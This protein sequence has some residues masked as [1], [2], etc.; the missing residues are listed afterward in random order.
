MKPKP[1]AEPVK[2]Y[3]SEFGKRFAI[4]RITDCVPIRQ[5]KS[6]RSERQKRAAKRLVLMSKLNSKEAKAGEFASELLSEGCVVLDT[7]TTGLSEYDQVIEIGICDSQGTVLLEQR[8][9]PTVSINPEAEAVHGITMSDLESCPKWPEAIHSIKKILEGKTVVIFNA[10]FD[11]G[12][13]RSTCKA[14]GLDDS[15]LDALDVVCAMGLSAQAFGATNRYDTISLANA[16]CAAGVTWS[17]NAHSA[18]VDALAT[19]GVIAALDRHYKELM[20]ELDDCQC[21]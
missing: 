14:F 4:Y 2:F 11:I 21:S 9:F 18:S 15:W 1:D 19:L 20:T 13:M 8:F 6:A 5:V 17:G 10:G 12:M 3:K 16:A 7:E